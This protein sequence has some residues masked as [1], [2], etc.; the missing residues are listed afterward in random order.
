VSSVPLPASQPPVPTAPT[1]T[2]DP[3]ADHARGRFA[4]LINAVNKARKDEMPSVLW[5]KLGPFLK[6]ADY[7]HMGVASLKVCMTEAENTG[8]IETGKGP[9]LGQEWVALPEWSAKR[10]ANIHAAIMK[11]RSSTPTPAIPSLPSLTFSPNSAIPI[12]APTSS[13]PN[14][15]SQPAADS[16]V[17]A[18]TRFTPLLAAIELCRQGDAASVKCSLVGMNLTRED[19]TFMSVTK[20]SQ[21]LEAAEKDGLVTRGGVGGEAWVALKSW[22]PDPFKVPAVSTEFLTQL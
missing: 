21:C 18:S 22:Q 6:K 5:S 10:R 2:G 7:I 12:V 1:H 19:Y 20:W 14:G 8:I 4:P 13:T 9:G 15:S 17:P 11:S 16:L 3:V